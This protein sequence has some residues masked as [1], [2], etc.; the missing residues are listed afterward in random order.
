MAETIQGIQSRGVVACAKHYILNEQ[1]HYRGSVDVRIDDRTMHEV[2][3]WPFADAVK[4]GVGSVMCSYNKING[5]Y[6]CEN[7][8]TTNYLLKNEL[9]FQGFGEYGSVQGLVK[10]VLTNREVMSDWGAQHTT[11]GSA[12]GGLDMAMPGD[13]GPPP[14]RA[15]WGGALTETVLKGDVPQWRIDDM[16]VRIMTAYFLVHT[17]NYTA[18]PDINFSAWTNKTTGPLH[19]SSNSS[20][21]VVNEFVD[22]QANHAALIREIGAKS[23]VLLKNDR[24]I[25]PLSSPASLAIIGDDAQDN[26]GGPNACPDRACLRGTTAMG[27]GSGTAEFPYLISPASAIM[28]YL[29]GTNT[30]VTNTSSNWDVPAAKLAASKAEV[31]IVFAGVTSGEGYRKSS[32]RGLYPLSALSRERPNTQSSL[33]KADTSFF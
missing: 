33:T 3:L 4:A 16:A 32:P 5:T 26:P 1:E 31:A 13:G 22:V 23:I 9:G 2:Y 18:R 27:Y 20:I 21:T 7:E 19:P 12:L 11:L 28:A 14:Y 17:G 10:G 30:T 25:L 24:N 8:W 6:A 15:W 29:A